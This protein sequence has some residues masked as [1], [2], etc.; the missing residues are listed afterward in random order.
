MAYSSPV[1]PIRPD[2]SALLGA[3]PAAVKPAP[4]ADVKPDWSELDVTTLSPDLQAAYFDYKKLAN[5]A[6]EHRKVFE[7][8]MSAKVELADHLKLIFGYNFGKLSVAIVPAEQVRKG[9]RLAM[10]LA[11]LISR[12][13]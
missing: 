2:L 13:E 5:A 9:S 10:S 3:K 12:A 8:A 1:R 4:A 6:T 11:D 7:T